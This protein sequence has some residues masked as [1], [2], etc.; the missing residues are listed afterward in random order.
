MELT[1]TDIA[2]F[3]RIF[4]KL[5]GIELD[6]DNAYRLL[7]RMVRQVELVYQPITQ[8]QLDRYNDENGNVQN[9]QSRA[10]SDC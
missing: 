2:K 6:R 9:E 5:Y 8:E 10:A 7:A 4:R 3:Q 1:D